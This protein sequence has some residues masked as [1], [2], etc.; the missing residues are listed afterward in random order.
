MISQLYVYGTENMPKVI[1][2]T[3][4]KE[5][6]IPVGF[7]HKVATTVAETVSYPLEVQYFI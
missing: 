6:N 7:E 2:Y 4:L 5:A 1:I 3:N